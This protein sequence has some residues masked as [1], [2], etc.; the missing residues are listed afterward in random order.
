M[1]RVDR[2]GQRI[3]LSIKRTQ[4]DPWLAVEDRFHIEDTV[5]GVVTHLVRFGAFVELEPGIEGLVH[6]SELGEGEVQSPAEVVAEGQAVRVMIL[7]IDIA[8]HQ[9]GL[10]I[11]RASGEQALARA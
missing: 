7:S 1:L 9:M 8:R 2:E 10:S 6:L 4:P 11:R 5:S 3:G